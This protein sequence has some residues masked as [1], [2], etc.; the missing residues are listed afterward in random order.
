[1]QRKPSARFSTRASV[2]RNLSLSSTI[3]T[4]M[5]MAAIFYGR[6]QPDEGSLVRRRAERKTSADIF[7]AFSHVAQ[8]ISAGFLLR[9]GRTF[10]IVLD[11]QRK[12]RRVQSQS[13]VY[14]RRLRVLH[15]VVDRFLE[16][17]EDIM[18]HVRRQRH[19]RQ[20]ARNIHAI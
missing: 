7:H 3:E 13:N 18:P 16:R 19:L 15:H 2:S 20:L 9:A 17:Q 8:S 5:G 11:L 10:A 12:M 6:R 1:M 14:F 4:L